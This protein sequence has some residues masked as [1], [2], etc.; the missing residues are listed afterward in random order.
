MSDEKIILN[1]GKVF[2]PDGSDMDNNDFVVFYSQCYWLHN[3]K[4]VD[5]SVLKLRYKKKKEYTGEDI[6]DILAWKMGRIKGTRDGKLEY[7]K[8]WNQDILEIKDRIK[9]KQESIEGILKTCKEA[10]GTVKS[11]LEGF[12]NQSGIGPVY[13][14]ALRYFAEACNDSY[15]PVYSKRPLLGWMVLP[16]VFLHNSNDARC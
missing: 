14:L 8:G 7:Y 4:A 1:R 5:D 10:D 9:C 3:R 13:A 11:Y 6:F 16:T 12:K 2:Y 15:S